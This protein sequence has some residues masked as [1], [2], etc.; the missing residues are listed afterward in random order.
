MQNLIPGVMLA[1]KMLILVSY[2]PTSPPAQGII[3]HLA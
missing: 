2:I 3:L 1:P